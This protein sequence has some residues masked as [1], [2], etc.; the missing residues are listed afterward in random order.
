MQKGKRPDGKEGG[1]RRGA[2]EAFSGGR[3][4]DYLIMR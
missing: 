1:N 4:S 3:E 2:G